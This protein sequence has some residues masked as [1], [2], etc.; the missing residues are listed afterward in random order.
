MK[1]SDNALH[2]LISRSQHDFSFL[3]STL[4]VL[5]IHP[6]LREAAAAALMPPSRFKD[7]LYVLLVGGGHLVT[8]LRPKKH[9]IHPSGQSNRK[10]LNP[11]LHLLLTVI[12]SSAYLRSVETWLPICLPKFNPAGFVH[13]YISY[14]RQDVGLV[15]VSADREAFEDLRGWKQVVMRVRMRNS[16]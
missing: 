3:T 11:D 13:A 4:Q 10:H 1:G 8:L 9:H 12:S 6:S 7:L 16:G 5:R 14:I 15:F 2:A